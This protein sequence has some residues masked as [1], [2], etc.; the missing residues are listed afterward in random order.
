MSDHLSPEQRSL[1][2]RL[3]AHVLHS[4]VDSKQHTAPART[5]F[6]K[7]FEDEVDPARVLPESE[8]Q[9]RAE[10]AKTA[11]FTALAIKSAKARARRTG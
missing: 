6:M 9:R 5:T 8:R 10:H 1:R 7:R 11:Y 4:R 2:A 3:A